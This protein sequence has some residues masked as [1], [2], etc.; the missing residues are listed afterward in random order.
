MS[1]DKRLA[2]TNETSIAE[3]VWNPE[4]VDIIKSMIAKDSTDEELNLFAQI[5]ARTGLDPFSR[6][7]YAIKRWDGAQKRH[8]MNVQVSIDG[9][10]LIAERTGQYG[11]QVGP[12]WCGRDGKWRDVW[13]ENEPP[14][15]AKVG[16]IRLGWQEPL[17]AV[18]RYDGYVQTSRDQQPTPMWRRMPDVMLA[19]CAESLALRKAFP[20]EL[21]G[22]YTSDE[23]QQAQN[24]APSAPVVTQ[25]NDNR[26]VTADGEIVDDY[27]NAPTPEPITH[28]QI[29]KL[30]I[31]KNQLD[32]DDE[33]FKGV[34][35]SHYKV[36]SRKDLTKDQASH[37]INHLQS[38][39]FEQAIAACESMDDL[40]TIA[41][42]IKAA[43]LEGK[44]R[45][46]LLNAYQRRENELQSGADDPE[47]DAAWEQAEVTQ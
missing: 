45:E 46:R 17:Y 36:S 7:I 10:R 37:L 4:Q 2:T 5:C 24:P 13:L 35:L 42:D 32:I 22:L 19:K 11:G 31:L 40:Q 1:D 38:G 9:F 25:R 20:Q 28:A 14:A 43:G 44:P 47:L 27:L 16:V 41:G 21:S 29:S 39:V 30:S 18:A 34:W 23:M 8:V 6:Q 3:Q 33:T 26:T 12:F 15:A